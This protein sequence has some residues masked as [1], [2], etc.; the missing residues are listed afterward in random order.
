MEDDLNT[1]FPSMDQTELFLRTLDP[2][3]QEFDFRTFDDQKG[4]KRPYLNKKI[5]GKYA[6]VRE[7]LR[8]LNSRGAG[9]FAV[10]NEGGQTDDTITRIRAFFADT[11][12][13]PPRPIFRALRPHLVVNSSEGRYH[14]YWRI[15]AGVPIHLFKP[16]QLAIAKTFGTDPAVC[17]PS[18]VMRLP[19]YYHNKRDPFLVASCATAPFCKPYNLLEVINGLGLTFPAEMRPLKSSDAGVTNS[20]LADKLATIENALNH[21]DPW[22]DRATWMKVIFALADTLGEDGRAL[23]IRWSSGALWSGG[24]R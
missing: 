15:S 23:A 21:I 24:S 11:D 18:R 9:I 12:G 16:I 19:G 10:I 7:E 17:N 2:R 4:K 13:A 14:L 5:R 3:A 8:K 22:S 20:S 1:T 6:D